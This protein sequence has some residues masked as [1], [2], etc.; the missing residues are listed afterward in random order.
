MLKKIEQSSF[1]VVESFLYMHVILI[2]EGAMFVV[3]QN[4]AGSL[5]SN[6]GSN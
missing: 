5:K 1:Y 6:F 4:F 3:Y 2:R